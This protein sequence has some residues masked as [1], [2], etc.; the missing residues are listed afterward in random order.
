V[1]RG[2]TLSITDKQRWIEAG[3]SIT[4]DAVVTVTCAVGYPLG[5]LKATLSVVTVDDALRLL[6]VQLAA[7][8]WNAQLYLPETNDG[9]I[10]AAEVSAVV[11]ELDHFENG[12][13]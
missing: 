12:R 10:P 1:Q 6:P 5:D 4:A 13:C 9:W 7:D 8:P 2:V 11:T 3:T